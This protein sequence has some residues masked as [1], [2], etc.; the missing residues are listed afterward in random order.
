MR[1]L[2]GVLTEG[3]TTTGHYRA[4]AGGWIK[5]SGLLMQT[6]SSE[7]RRPDTSKPS[8]SKPKRQELPKLP[9]G[10]GDE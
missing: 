1:S 2:F 10:G 8:A 3:R 4:L 5:Q 7:A 9:S 6:P